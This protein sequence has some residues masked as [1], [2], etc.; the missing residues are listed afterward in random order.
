[1]AIAL[2]ILAASDAEEV[3]YLLAN[4]IEE[5][6]NAQTDSSIHSADILKETENMQFLYPAKLLIALS[7]F[8][9]RDDGMMFMA[10][11]L[12][13]SNVAGID[14]KSLHIFSDEDEALDP[15][16]SMEVMRLFQNPKMFVREGGHD[17]RHDIEAY[18]ARIRRELLELLQN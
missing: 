1:M 10:Q 11:R 16:L 8:I 4:D 3:R 14:V 18:T 13:T 5:E 2:C 7:G 15:Q 9:P 12:L 17:P 6:Y